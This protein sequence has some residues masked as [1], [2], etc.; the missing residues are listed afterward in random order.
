MCDIV[1]RGLLVDPV[2]GLLGLGFQTIAS[3]RAVPFWE[4]LVEHGAW[5]EPVMTFQL[6]RFVDQRETN[7]LEPGGSFTMGAFYSVNYR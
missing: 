1:S 5:D 2:S 4:S 3:S 7:Q 6:T